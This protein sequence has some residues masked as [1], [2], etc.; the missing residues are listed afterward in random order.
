M[1]SLRAERSNLFPKIF[2]YDFRVPDDEEKADRIAS[3]PTIHFKMLLAM[4]LKG[5]REEFPKK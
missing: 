5:F 1:L 3:S 2:V 4:T